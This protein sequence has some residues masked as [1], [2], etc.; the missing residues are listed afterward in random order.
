MLEHI[1]PNQIQDLE[2]ARQAIIEILNLVEGLAAQVQTLREENQRLRDEN[3][4]LRGEQGKP[5]IKPSKKASSSVPSDYSS[6]PERRTPRKRTKRPKVKRIQ[7]GREEKLSLD[8][9]QLP[10]DVVH[11]G[12]EA[13]VVQD[14]RLTTDNV[15]FW[16]EKCYSPS[17]QQSYLAS[18]PPGYEGEFG[19][20]IKALILALYHALNG[21]EPK[22]AE[23]LTH[24]GV[25]ISSGQVSNLLIKEQDAFHAEKDAVYEAGLRSSPWQHV[26]ETSTRVDGVNQHC[27][28]LCTPVYTVYLTIPKKDRLHLIDLLTNLRPRTYRLLAQTYAWLHQ[29]SVPESVLERLQGL[30]QDQVLDDE[31][32]TRLLDEHLPDVNAQHQR[33]IREAAAITAYHTQQDIPVVELLICDDAPQFK[34]VTAELALCWVHDARYYKKLAPAVAHH[35]RLLAAFMD[36][37]WAFYQDLLAYRQHPSPEQVPRLESAFDDLFSTV[38]GYTGLDRRIEMT[39]DKKAALLMVLR[40]PEIPLHNNPAE[41]EMRRRVRKRDVSFGPRTEQGK[42]AWDTFATLLATTKKLGVSFY[43]YIY[44]RVSMTNEIPKLADLIVQRAQQMNLAASWQSA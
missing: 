5:T 26:D 38:T 7:V 17:E 41:I 37:Y 23:F 6:E 8:R 36:R 16:K 42:Q 33:L 25:Q 1:D 39:R 34:R 30:P 21:S 12:H 32:F 43:R 24:I 27:Y 13:V 11:K 3:N 44:D 35:R 20:G 31:Q 15:R 40:H 19:P 14:V 2:Q 9:S 28:V 29:A 10:A 22:V 4:R 18:L